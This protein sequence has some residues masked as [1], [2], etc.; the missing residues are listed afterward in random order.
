M[1]EQKLT[2]TDI[3][4]VGNMLLDVS[5]H[6]DGSDMKIK[7]I[8]FY[9]SEVSGYY[10]TVMEYEDSLRQSVNVVLVSGAIMTVFI[11]YADFQAHMKKYQRLFGVLRT[12]DEIYQQL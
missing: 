2:V 5:I 4:F 11:N 3:C 6:E 10:Q 9:L 12:D 8:E 7:P 1:T